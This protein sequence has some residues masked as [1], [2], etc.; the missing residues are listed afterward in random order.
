MSLGWTMAASVTAPWWRA[1]HGCVEGFRS[2]LRRERAAHGRSAD[3]GGQHTGAGGEPVPAVVEDHEV[4]GLARCDPP[5]HGGIVAPTAPQADGRD[6]V[7]RLDRAEG[8]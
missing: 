2:S 1:A 4:G 5:G 6:R 8:A 3:E 7:D